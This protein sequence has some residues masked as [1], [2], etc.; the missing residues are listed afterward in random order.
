MGCGPGA[1]VAQ[2]RPRQYD[3]RIGAHCLSTPGLIRKFAVAERTGRRSLAFYL[4]KSKE[5]G[6]CIQLASDRSVHRR[7]QNHWRLVAAVDAPA[8]L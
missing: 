7:G 1:P 6:R 5:G 2:A 3:Y 8:K 4:W